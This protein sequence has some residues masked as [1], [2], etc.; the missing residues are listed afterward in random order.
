MSK[1]SICTISDNQ[2]FDLI[3]R[4]DF[5]KKSAVYKFF[6]PSERKALDLQFQELI[7][8]IF[9]QAFGIGDSQHT[10]KIWDYVLK[11][12]NIKWKK[13]N[14][15][16]GEDFKKIHNAF[17]Q[18]L[19]H[20]GPG[21]AYHSDEVEA[22]VVNSV[23]DYLITHKDGVDLQDVPYTECFK[24]I[25]WSTDS[26][27]LVSF[28]KEL[29]GAIHKG[30]K[31]FQ[32][33]QITEEVFEAFLYHILALYPHSRPEIGHEI[34]LPVKIDGEWQLIDYR[35]DKKFLMTPS[36]LS[37]PHPI[38]GLRSDVENAPSMITCTGTNYP[39]GEGFIA[40]ILADFTPFM[41]VGHAMSLYNQAEVTQWLE[42]QSSVHMTGMSLGGVLGLHTA[43]LNPGLVD[44]V[45]G[46]N[47]PGLYS[48]NWKG[49]DLSTEFNIYSNENDLVSTLGFF[50][51][52]EN[53]NIFRI[54]AEKTEEFGTTHARLYEGSHNR[55]TFVRSNP[56]Y[57]NGRVERKIITALHFFFG[58]I[59]GAIVLSY[60][61][62][63]RVG[64]I[65]SR[66][67]IYPCYSR[68]SVVNEGENHAG[69]LL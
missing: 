45:Y 18:S 25:F 5:Q 34:Q 47:P 39:A 49:R 52:G 65:F 24:N 11:I 60:N 28:Q 36:W 22:N 32:E 10:A 51:K 19:V 31:I 1:F 38:F 15:L 30:F 68:S 53:V 9:D 37:S 26:K 55:V 40:G 43:R 6:H 23:L 57:E 13:S 29:Q 41:S 50:P 3:A 27:W 8:S 14:A 54:L 66:I 62:I 16:S 7:F 33:N 67:I 64:E 4:Q 46:F 17:K 69:K 2:S 44:K 20:S 58:W 61:A 56:E 63:Y 59:P 21:I 48:W 42:Q 35:V 12:H